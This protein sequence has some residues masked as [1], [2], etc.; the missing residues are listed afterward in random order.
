MRKCSKCNK[1]IK[2]GPGPWLAHQLDGYCT[3]DITYTFK[4][5]I[6]DAPPV[7]WQDWDKHIKIFKK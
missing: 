6:S 2:F 4:G 7:N 1:P 5:T 3:C